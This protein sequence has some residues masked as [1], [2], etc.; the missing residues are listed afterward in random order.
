[1][2][3]GYAEWKQQ[4]NNNKKLCAAHIFIIPRH[5][6]RRAAPR[7]AVCLLGFLA[8]ALFCSPCEKERERG[9]GRERKRS[10]P[11]HSMPLPA[12]WV[13]CR[14]RARAWTFC[15]IFWPSSAP[16]SRTQSHFVLPFLPL[17]AAV[18]RLF[19]CCCFAVNMKSQMQPMP[20]P[21]MR[22]MPPLLMT[23]DATG[24]CA[25]FKT[26]VNC[27]RAS[28]MAARA[29]ARAGSSSCSAAIGCHFWS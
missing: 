12:H 20:M 8:L 2:A 11:W 13:A 18:F 14:E 21:P 15:H 26:E 22:P 7:R 17:S 24:S 10:V 6:S 1:M 9:E 3:T 5:K 28:A 4:N 25:K 29:R 16:L 19:G 23:F 27:Q